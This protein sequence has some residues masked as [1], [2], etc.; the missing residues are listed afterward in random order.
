M[1]TDPVL[2]PP[3]VS[4]FASMTALVLNSVSSPLTRSMYAK[5]LANFFSWWEEQGRPSFTRATVLTHRAFLEAKGY[6][7]STINQRLAAIRKLAIEAGDNDLL[8]LDHAAAIARVKGVRRAGVRTN[9]SL[10]EQQAE[11]LINAPTPETLKGKRDGAMLAL[12]V[13]CGLRRKELAT[14]KIEDI[15]QREGRWIILNLEG[16]HGRVRS[17]PV[18]S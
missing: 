7:A 8:P 4:P 6:A 14:L 2:L 5:A 1:A 13:G 10:T 3:L 12:L 11:Q 15:Q 9:N 16:K 17:V 18:P